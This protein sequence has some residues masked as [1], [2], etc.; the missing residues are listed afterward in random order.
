MT[1][2]PV[3]GATEMAQ[4]LR[5]FAVL[6]EDV[7][8]IPSTYVRELATPITSA[9]KN[10][11]LSGLCRQQHTCA[12]HSQRQ[13]NKNT[14][15]YKTKI[16]KQKPSNH[17]CSHVISSQACSHCLINSS[18]C[19]NHHVAYHYA[20]SHCMIRTLCSKYDLLIP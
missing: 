17:A 1:N 2:I 19:S 8:S 7:S 5:A 13:V 4:R 10:G 20:C 3:P 6:P 15:K 16:K 18:P 11:T 12:G 9:P 14:N